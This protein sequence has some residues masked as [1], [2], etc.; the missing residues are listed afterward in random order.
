MTDN[1]YIKEKQ[2][3]VIGVGMGLYALLVQMK[4]ISTQE[5]GGGKVR[6]ASLRGGK[7]RGTPARKSAIIL[8]CIGIRIYLTS[9]PN[10]G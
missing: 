9:A 2:R 8:Q 5:W 7:M 3:C 10:T 6:S 1:S 4:K